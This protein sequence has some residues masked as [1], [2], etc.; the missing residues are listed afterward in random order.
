VP[1]CCAALCGLLFLFPAPAAVGQGLTG[2]LF[3]TIRDQQGGI[4]KGAEV[5]VSSPALIGGP[6]IQLTNDKGQLRFPSL[7]PGLY[8]LE[9]RL[10]G[11]TARREEG[12]AIGS[13]ATIERAIVLEPAGVAES[14]TVD[15]G[16]S[17]IDARDPGFGARFGPED[18]RAIPSRRSSWYDAMRMVPGVSPT[19]PSSG[20]TTTISA[21]G[22]GV[23]ENQFLIDGTNTTCPCN[24]VARSEPGVDFIQEVQ[25]QSVG[26][27]AEFGNVQ[28][29]VINVIT[30]QGSERFAYDASYYGQPPGLTG[31]PVRLP[32]NT[33][34][35]GYERNRY[36]DFTTN[37]GGPAIKNRLWFFGGYQHLRDYDSQP[38]TDPELPRKY[39]QDKIF[40]RLTWNLAPGWRLDQSYHEEFWESPDQPRFNAPI[41]TTTRN[42]AHVPAF[43]FGHLTHTM[44]P[45]TVWEARVGRFVYDADAPPYY[46]DTSTPSVLDTSTS[47]RSGA[48]QSFNGLTLIRT[49]GKV[50]LNHYRAGV[51]GAD[52]AWKMGAQVERGEHHT[53]VIIPTGVRFTNA[54]SVPI[55]ATYAD[56]SN[57]GAAF[58]TTGLFVTDAITVGDRLTVN[59]GVRYDRSRAFSQDLPRVDY[60]GNETV[61]EFTSTIHWSVG[62][63]AIAPFLVHALRKPADPR[64]RSAQAVHGVDSRES[65]RSA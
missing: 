14:V 43:T 6:V 48:P 65:G 50:T 55:S 20:T 31:Q 15:G 26:A 5:R 58:L 37:L 29:A 36:R 25:V 8:V 61:R 49:V 21:F 24:G 2:T 34:E 33:G 54:G 16:S 17:R 51:W 1:R 28:G 46:G 11:F 53:Y 45:R 42:H 10:P 27:S 32:Y 4:I 62:L 59:A 35:S 52:H 13:G 41:E 22:S 18:L 39:E 64:T 40:A 44:S 60:A 63:L 9:V 57:T 12:I 38:G 7:P 30:R 47:V 19:S 56:P 23:N 3:G